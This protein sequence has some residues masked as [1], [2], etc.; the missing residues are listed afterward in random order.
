[1][2]SLSAGQFEAVRKFTS[3]INCSYQGQGC[4]KLI[5]RGHP[6]SRRR[7]R[8][9]RAPSCESSRPQTLLRSPYGSRSHAVRFNVRARLWPG[10]NVTWYKRDL[11]QTW[12][13]T[14][15]AV[16]TSSSLHLCSLSLV[17]EPR[18]LQKYRIKRK[19]EKTQILLCWMQTLFLNIDF[20]CI[21]L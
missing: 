13:G 16:P 7:A 9:P 14:N 11:V 18:S 8:T 1:M 19:S 20:H 2:T 17:F 3:T 21:T 6:V 5:F 15:V 10:T 12:P 4:V